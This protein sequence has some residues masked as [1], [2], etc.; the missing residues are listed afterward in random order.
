MFVKLR[1]SELEGLWV[2]IKLMKWFFVITIKWRNVS[3]WNRYAICRPLMLSTRESKEKCENC[4]YD[5]FVDFT[6]WNNKLQTWGK[7]NRKLDGWIW[8]RKLFTV[9]FLIC[10]SET[11]TRF[12]LST[13]CRKLDEGGLKSW[14][15]L[16]MG[17]SID[18]SKNKQYLEI[19][20]GSA[21]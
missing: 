8:H 14:K 2:L 6:Q 5:I 17:N 1:V 20:T 9:K 18:T 15:I 11:C 12:E 3:C 10:V 19:L 21:Y 7:F 16:K 4:G 13:F